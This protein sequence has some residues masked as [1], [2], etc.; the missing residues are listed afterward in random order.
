MTDLIVYVYCPVEGCRARMAC[1]RHLDNLRATYRCAPTTRRRP[2]MPRR[3]HRP[4]KRRTYRPAPPLAEQ[5]LS[6][7][8]QGD[9][10]RMARNLVNGGACSTAILGPLGPRG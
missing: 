10:S 4:R 6:A 8:D 1:W 5:E 7:R 2:S 9:V 3:N